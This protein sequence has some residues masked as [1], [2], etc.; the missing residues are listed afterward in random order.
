MQ[1]FLDNLY[2]TPPVTVSACISL[3]FYLTCLFAISGYGVSIILPPGIDY[4]LNT[5]HESLIKLDQIAIDN[6][7][8][9]DYTINWLAG[10]YKWSGCNNIT[11]C[12]DSGNLTGNNFYKNFENFRVANPMYAADLNIV[13]NTI[14]SSRVIF[15]YENDSDGQNQANAMKT[16]RTDLEKKSDL[17]GIF[18]ISI[19]F[20]YAEQYAKVLGDTIQNLI[21][22]ACAIVVITLFYLIHPGITALVFLSFTSLI[23]ELLG[24]MAAWDTSLDAI[25]MIVII[26]A[27]GFSVDYTCHV[28]HAFMISKKPTADKRVMDAVTTM[29]SSVLNGGK[30]FHF[31][32]DPV[33]NVFIYIFSFVQ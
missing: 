21:I 8:Y 5:T 15:F 17:K 9:E 10:Y 16:I 14:S 18:A 31:T 28:A 2:R 20:I 23:F 1:N 13:N 12:I 25:A 6:S 27:I 3:L 11:L 22:C 7:R 30:C 32:K 24:L 26:M 33:L 4:T 19:M 29:G